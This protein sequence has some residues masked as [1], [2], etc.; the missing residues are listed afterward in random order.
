MPAL[1]AALLMS[2]IVGLRYLM[3]S[4]MFAAI[5]RSTG[6]A[7]AIPV[8]QVRAEIKWSLLSALI[9]GAP[10][11]IT[12]WAWNRHGLTQLYVDPRVQPLWLLWASPLLYLF[13]HDTWFY[14]TH[15]L[16]HRPRWFR[17]AHAVHHQSRPP[18]AWAAM[19]FHPW[20]AL[21]GAVL[22]PALAWVVPIHVGM[23]GLVLLIAS[24]FGTTN[25]M[26]WEMLP[27]RVVRGPV[28]AA[29]ISAAHHE[30]HHRNYRANFGLYFRFWD[31]ICGTDRGIAEDMLRSPPRVMPAKAGT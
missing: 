4:G 22:F 31:R 19:S 1:A 15:R 24:L 6:R 29:L 11:G 27:A 23:L 13:V 8:G 12:Y 5:T 28:G 26:G 16:M 9:Y 3:L 18:T 17:V 21:S 25:H 20:E 14:W 7:R 10:A 2:L 30:L